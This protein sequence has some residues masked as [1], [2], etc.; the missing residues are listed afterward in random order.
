LDADVIG[1]E[2]GG[3]PFF[4][5]GSC[6]TSRPPRGAAT[7][8]DWPQRCRGAPL[9]PPA[10][11]ARLLNVVALAGRPVSFDIAKQAGDWSPED[12][13]VLGVLRVGA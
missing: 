2:S 1:R 4:I 12:Y 7:F 13:S 11:A 10:P 9:A 6:D 3:S 8:D 5:D